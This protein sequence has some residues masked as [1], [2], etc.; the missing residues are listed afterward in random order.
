MR[1]AF[2]TL[3]S[4]LDTVE[5]LMCTKLKSSGSLEALSLF[6]RSKTFRIRGQ[7][8]RK[9]L[10]YRRMPKCNSSN[11]IYFPPSLSKNIPVLHPN[12]D[13]LSEYEVYKQMK[14]WHQHSHYFRK[15]W[16]CQSSNDG[17]LQSSLRL[18]STVF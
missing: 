1:S 11:K 10:H 7:R 2:G 9:P 5:Y 8:K 17:R 12:K 3:N 6:L 14:R 4:R 16:A 15:E 18:T 13:E